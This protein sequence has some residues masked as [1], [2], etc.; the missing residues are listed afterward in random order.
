MPRT[1]VSPYSS[2]VGSDGLTDRQRDIIRLYFVEGMKMSTISAALRYSLS[3]IEKEK[4]TALSVLQMSE[5]E[6]RQELRNQ[7][8]EIYLRVAIE[9]GGD[10]AFPMDTTANEAHKALTIPG[11]S[12][13][14][15]MRDKSPGEIKEFHRKHPRSIYNVN[16]DPHEK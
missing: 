10:V 2:L 14:L 1:A 7:N 6:M 9:R 4:S 16:E 5:E 12:R 8:G 11:Y 15:R 13:A 3:T